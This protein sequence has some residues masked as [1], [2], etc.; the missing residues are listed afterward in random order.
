MLSL[1]ASY[2]WRESITLSGG[3]QHVWAFDAFD[4]L[5]P[6]PDLPAYSDVIVNTK[7][8]TGGLDWYANDRVSAY[9]RYVYEDY[10]DAS[11]TYVSGSAHMFLGGFTAYY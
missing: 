4:P 3:L 2:A 10:D 9:M 7:R 11:I 6:W 8:Y 5:T 1:G